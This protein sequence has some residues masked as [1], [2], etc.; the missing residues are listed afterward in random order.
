MRNA[1]EER[2]DVKINNP[3][4]LP[5]ALPSHGQRVM[6]RT[7]RTVTVAVRVEDQLKLLLQ[8]HRSRKIAPRRHPVPQLVEVALFLA[9]EHGDAD[10]VHARR[11]IV[12]PDLLPRLID[13]A[14]RYLK[15]LHLRLRFN[16]RLIPRRV[17]LQ[18]TLACPAP[19]LQDHYSPF[20]ATT[21]RSARVP[22][23]GTLP[24]TVSAARGP[25]SR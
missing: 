17:D 13:K 5:A 15:R 2:P 3:V 10:G 6:S 22:R 18:L 21:S 1:V 16:H 20:I 8:Q 7:P 19:W 4:V 24:L 23:L 11:T 9:G 12:G 25:P 14:L